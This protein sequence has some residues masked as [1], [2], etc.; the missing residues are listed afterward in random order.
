[1]AKELKDLSKSDEIEAWSWLVLPNI[2]RYVV[3]S[4][5]VPAGTGCVSDATP[6]LEHQSRNRSQQSAE[7]HRRLFETS[8][9][10][11]GCGSKSLRL[12]VALPSS[13]NH[14]N[15][16]LR[17]EKT[18]YEQN[19]EFVHNIRSIYKSVCYNFTR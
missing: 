2:R 4:G 19:N 1:M 13:Q 14:A 18:G 6:N 16:I 12:R 7:N 15:K 5:L 17:A 10:N 3:A 9:L 11:L 8:R